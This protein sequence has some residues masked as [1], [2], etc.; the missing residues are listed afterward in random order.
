[1]SLSPHKSDVANVNGIRLHYLD[2]GGHGPVILFLTGSGNSAHIYDQFAPHFTDRFHVMA[3]TRRGHGDSDYP[4][5]GYDPDTLTEDV[6]QFLDLLKIDKVIL[7]GHSM[8]K[9]ELC[10]FAAL[11]PE[12]LLKLVF[13]DAAY[14]GTSPVIKAWVEKNPLRSITI[15]DQ[16]D[17]YYSIEE[18]IA[19]AKRK[20]PFWAAMWCD[21]VHEDLLHIVRQSPEGKIVEKMPST[22]G[23]ALRETLDS[24]VPEFSKIQVPVLSIFAVP[25][26]TDYISHEYMTDEQ[27]ALVVEFFEVV[28]PPLQKELVEQFRRAVPHAKIVEIPRGHHYCF[29]KQEQFVFDEMSKFLLQ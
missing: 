10:H 5:T 17:E 29:I 22:I 26:S 24:Y 4:E 7:A 27:I 9:V 6:R 13:L 18:Y 2:W 19:S 8:S 15:P 16:N 23:K 1:L 20:Y 11:Y 12:R 21:A 25:D 14:D 28:R 3:L